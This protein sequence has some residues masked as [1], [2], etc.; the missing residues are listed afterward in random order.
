MPRA[1][2]DGL[3]AVG[4]TAIPVHIDDT[5]H[6]ASFTRLEPGVRSE[7]RL[8]LM[9]KTIAFVIYL[10]EHPEHMAA[11]REFGL[12]LLEAAADNSL[13]F[14]EASDLRWMHDDLLP[15]DEVLRWFDR[16]M[17]LADEGE[18]VGQ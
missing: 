7:D 10:Q 15:Q 9:Q 3:L 13:S 14:S 18:V 2:A 12:R 8:F 16:A 4:S 11:Y 6:T 1:C 17:E 5:S